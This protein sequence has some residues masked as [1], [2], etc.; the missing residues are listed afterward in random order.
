MDYKKIDI[1]FTSDEN[2]VQHM[3][4]AI[5]SILKNSDEK[6]EFHFF[7]VD[8][9]ISDDSKEKIEMLKL[10]KNFEI[11]YIF[12]DTDIFRKFPRRWDG[13]SL[14]SYYLLL[15]PNIL[16]NKERLLFL[17]CDVVVKKSLLPLWSMDFEGRIILAAEDILNHNFRTP[18]GISDKYFYFNSGVFLLNCKKWRDNNL[19]KKCFEYVKN[20]G[21]KF[22][23]QDQEVLNGMLHRDAKK[24][25]LKWNFQFV[26]DNTGTLDIKDFERAKANPVIIHY[27]TAAKPWK[28]ETCNYLSGEY[29]KYFVMTPFYEN[30]QNLLVEKINFLS[31]EVQ[32][33]SNLKKEHSKLTENHNIL[34]RELLNIKKSYKWR[35]AIFFNS[36][37]SRLFPHGTIRRKI[38]RMGYKA[39]AKIIVI[40]VRGLKIFKKN[41]QKL[42]MTL[43]VRDE[44][45]IVE[46][47]IKFHLRNGVDLIIATDNASV[48]GTRDI[49]VKYQNKGV[50]HLIDE[51]E[52]IHAQSKW[53]NR[54]TKIAVE[55]YGADIVFHCDADE[56]WRPKTGNLKKEMINS[57]VDVMSVNVVNVLPDS[58]GFNNFYND[59]I[60]YAIINPINTKKL[61]EDSKN[62]NIYFFKYP[63][64]VIFRTHNKLL[65]V[66]EGNHTIINDEKLKKNVSHNIDIYH[67]PLR[68]KEIF[69]RKVKQGGSALQNNKNLSENVGW[70]WRGWY[71][72]YKNG[73]LDNEYKKLLL[74]KEQVNKMKKSGMIEEISF[75]DLT[76]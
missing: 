20:N 62:T 8:D 57:D 42:V 1:C 40:M 70:H 75:N 59:S 46:R 67:F 63:S 12:V 73:T 54:M 3:A 27:I 36:L 2:Y 61:K 33:Y 69:F 51:K 72:S 14:N 34:K 37:F 48:D 74:S 10:I 47:N 29:W 15:V 68:D 21:H 60:K 35:I 30:N 39:I 7:I 19:E 9:N 25:D 41:K 4:V 52:H 5:S 43:L 18:R 24:I 55:K 66:G 71:K 58:S 44:V 11:D 50:L 64:K 17:D 22:Q 26:N 49:L 32:K 16:K 76:K 31:Q 6:D 38:L 23:F 65:D 53:V 56:F 28:K 13:L 45:D